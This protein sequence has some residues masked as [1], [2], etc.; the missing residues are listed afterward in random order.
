MIFM[1]TAL[2]SREILDEAPQIG[3][4]GALDEEEEDAGHDRVYDLCLE[5]A[6]KQFGANLMGR[7]DRMVIFHRLEAEQ[8]SGILNRRIARLNGWLRRHRY[9]VELRSG[10]REFLLERG[11]RNMKNGSRD[12]VRACQTFLEFPVADLMVSGRIPAGGH[13]L[14]DRMDGEEHLHFAVEGPPSLERLDPAVLRQ[15]PIA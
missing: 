6:T 1:T 13:V 9:Q 14:V 8:L 10:A 2:C 7:L 4:T 15:V 11:S 12:L 3:F 5:Q